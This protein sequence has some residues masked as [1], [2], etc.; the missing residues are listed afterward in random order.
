MDFKSYYSVL[1]VAPDAQ[2][3]TIQ[4]AYRRLAWQYHP[5]VNPGNKAAEEMFKAI[6][7][8]YRVLSDQDRRTRYDALQDDREGMSGRDPGGQPFDWGGWAR[9]Q[10]GWERG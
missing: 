1:G 9:P 8:A 7:E 4:Q 2:S 3:K 10:P 5:D 6:N